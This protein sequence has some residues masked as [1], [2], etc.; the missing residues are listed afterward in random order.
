M[1]PTLPWLMAHDRPSPERIASWKGPRYRESEF[2]YLPPV[3]RPPAFRDFDATAT[4]GGTAVDSRAEP[5]F[6]F[7]N[8]T[9]LVGHRASVH[10]PAGSTELDF[11]LELGVVIGH[12][13]INIPRARAWEHVFGFTILNDFSARD[14]ERRER[15]AGCGPAKSKD[16]ATAVG[17]WLV[18]RNVFHDRV[19]GE[20]LTLEVCGRVNGHEISRGNLAQ[21]RHSIPSMIERASRDAE[22]LPGDLIGTGTVDVGSLRDHGPARN[23]GWLKP[24]DVVEL[25]VERIG[26]LKTSIV[27]RPAP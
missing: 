18:S 17:P 13:G 7:S 25:E 3:V 1:K 11:E 4:P 8:P 22:L 19:D 20:T 10:A 21:L 15:S 27:A 26:I 2:A 16:F 14:V 24:G 23:G 5:A 9:T 6:Y 12:G